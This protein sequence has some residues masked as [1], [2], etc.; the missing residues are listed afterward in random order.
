MPAD[1]NKPAITDLY[2]GVL[3]QL[4]SNDSDLAIGLDPA[5]TTPVNIPNNAI[6]WSSTASKWQKYNSS[7]T[8]W[9]DLA[10]TYSISISG[11]AVTAQNLLLTDNSTNIANTA[12]VNSYV[13]T[14]AV[15]KDSATGSAALPVG[16]TAQRSPT[17]QGLL[18]FN[19]DLGRFEGNNGTAW[20]SLGGAAGGGS[21]SVFYLNDQ[22]INTSY[23]IAPAQN[24][25]TAGP[26]TVANGVVVT[27]SNG[28][29]W[30]VV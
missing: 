14:K 28:S 5:F 8:T 10:A 6:R 29:V 2:A 15:I 22:V 1:F 26:I 21:D 7:T 4:R 20:G 30:T 12:F 19:T 27:V 25:M 18:R 23:T 3:A 24:A 17:A 16:S 9:N 13:A 11:S